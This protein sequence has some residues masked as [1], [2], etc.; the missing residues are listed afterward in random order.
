MSR[1]AAVANGVVFCEEPSE[2]E[3]VINEDVVFCEEPYPGGGFFTPSTRRRG[4]MAIRADRLEYQNTARAVCARLAQAER[5]RRA[6]FEPRGVEGLRR[7]AGA[8]SPSKG[9]ASK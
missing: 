7:R 4:R 6:R 3:H 5:V 1:S 9:K 2:T 8:I